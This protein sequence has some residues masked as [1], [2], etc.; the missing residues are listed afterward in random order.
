LKNIIG[1]SR[2]GFYVMGSGAPVN[3]PQSNVQRDDAIKRLR[4]IF[5][6]VNHISTYSPYC[7][8]FLMDRAMASLVSDPRLSIE[9]RYG[10]RIFSLANWD[11]FLDWLD[12]LKTGMSEEHVA[13]L[14]AAYP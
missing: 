13:G 2:F 3:R 12:R 7:D 8:A 6:D 10:V 4:G 11:Q 9:Q 1:K 14:K 5:E